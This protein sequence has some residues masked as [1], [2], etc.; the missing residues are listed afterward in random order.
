[1]DVAHNYTMPTMP[2]PRNARNAPAPS[3][4]VFNSYEAPPTHQTPPVRGEYSTAR[5]MESCETL[6]LTRRPRACPRQRF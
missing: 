4:D 3:N 2:L 5:N 1:M 6:L